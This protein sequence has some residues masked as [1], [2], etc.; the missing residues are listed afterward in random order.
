VPIENVLGGVEGQDFYQL[1]NQLPWGRSMIGITALGAMD[2]G[3][4][5]T[6]DYERERK[7]LGQPIMAFQ[8]A[9][10]KL[11]EMKTKVEVT[12]SFIN[13]C[14]A[15]LIEVSL[16]PATALMVKYWGSQV[17]NEVLD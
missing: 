16:D 12:H 5:L 10:F 9:R 17:Q 15:K 13:D 4:Q 1:M 8:N 3:L 14:V 2:C 11:V 6:I 7:V